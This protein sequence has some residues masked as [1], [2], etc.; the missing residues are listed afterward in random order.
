M[1]RILVTRNFEIMVMSLHTAH[2][3]YCELLTDST[4]T[5]KMYNCT[6]IPTYPHI[7]VYVCMYVYIISL[8]NYCYMFRHNCNSQATCTNV[9]KNQSN[10]IIVR[11]SYIQNVLHLFKIYSI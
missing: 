7:C 2:S 3:V 8:L 4:S 5:N 9:V 11:Y 6:Y 10:K 1:I